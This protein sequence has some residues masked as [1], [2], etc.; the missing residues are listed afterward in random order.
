LTAAVELALALEQPR[1]PEGVSWADWERVVAARR[2]EPD[3]P[4]ARLRQLGPQLAPGEVLL[5]LD[6]VLAPARQRRHF[7]EVRTGRITTAAGTRY[8]S[9]VGAA[10][11][12]HVRTLVRLCLGRERPLL[13]IAHGAR[14]IRNFFQ[15]HLAALP[16]ATMLLD[17]YHLQHKCADL[18]SRVCRSRPAKAQFLRRLYRRL[19]AGE[20]PGAIRFLEA[21]R[22]A[23][24]NEAG[25]DTLINYLQARQAW[26]PNYR[27][28]RR[29]Q[30]YIGSG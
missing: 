19:W 29:A 21:Y 18:G 23:A 17:W 28:R 6:E 5:L 20:V 9:G 13:L 2:A 10:F 14:W 4:A 15:E 1:P 24:K 8:L 30:Q 26:I 22:P 7:Q 16:G 25:L 3:C 12:A 27:Q 11:L